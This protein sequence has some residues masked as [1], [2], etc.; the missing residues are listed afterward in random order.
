MCRLHPHIGLATVTY[1]FDGGQTHRDTIGSVRR[2]DPATS[3]G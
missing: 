2:S 1:L 3:T